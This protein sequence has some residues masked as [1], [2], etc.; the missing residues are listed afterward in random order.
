MSPVLPSSLFK[1]DANQISPNFQ[2]E[3]F[4]LETSDRYIAIPHKNEL[5]LGNELARKSRAEEAWDSSHQLI[6]PTGRHN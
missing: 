6:R 5:D 4:D 3:P 1:E 2:V